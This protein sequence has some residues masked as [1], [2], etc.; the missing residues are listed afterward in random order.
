MYW[1]PVNVAAQGYSTFFIDEPVMIDAEAAEEGGEMLGVTAVT[2]DA[3]TTTSLSVVD[4]NIPLLIFNGSDEKKAIN[5]IPTD[6][7]GLEMAFAPEY[8]GTLES[9]TFT[10][11]EMEQADHYVLNQNNFVWVRDA[12][13]I[14][15]SKCW[16]EIDN[17][18]DAKAPAYLDIVR[19]GAATGIST[20]KRVN[21]NNESLYDLQG[22][23]LTGTPSKAG[24]YILNG[25]KFVIK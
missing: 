14:G 17:G 16:L 13:T 24:I 5:L 11:A 20:V 3:V 25:K 10:A 18:V 22:R 2:E 12:G 4:G 19:G 21:L 9:K 8:K 23:R 6:A 1:Y 15:A 7:P